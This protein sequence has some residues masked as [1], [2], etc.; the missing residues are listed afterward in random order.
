MGKKVLETS[1]CLTSPF[2]LARLSLDKT[3]VG[4]ADLEVAGITAGM[5]GDLADLGDELGVDLGDV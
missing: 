1:T 2:R 3:G 4:G 5:G